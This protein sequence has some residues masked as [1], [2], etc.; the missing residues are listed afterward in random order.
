MWSF[1]FEVFLSNLATSKGKRGIKYLCVYGFIQNKDG[2]GV[3]TSLSFFFSP[4]SFSSSGMGMEDGWVS[5]PPDR[6]ERCGWRSTF[7]MLMDGWFGACW[8]HVCM[9]GC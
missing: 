1:V 4:S 9:Y 5:N 7:F 3:L 6:F 2:I 8:V